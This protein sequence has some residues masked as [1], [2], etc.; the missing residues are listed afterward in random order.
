MAA[1]TEG[2]VVSAGGSFSVTHS[3]QAAAGA[4]LPPL[5]SLLLV[6]ASGGLTLPEGG[7]SPS[8]LPSEVAPTA[9]RCSAAASG[10]SPLSAGTWVLDI[11]ARGLQAPGGG[12][13]ALGS[14]P[15][16]VPRPRLCPQETFVGSPATGLMEPLWGWGCHHLGLEAS[17]CAVAVSPGGVGHHRVACLA[18]CPETAEGLR[19]SAM[20]FPWAPRCREMWVVGELSSDGCHQLWPG[21]RGVSSRSLALVAT[22][23][24]SD[25]PLCPPLVGPGQAMV[26]RGSRPPGWTRGDMT[27][28]PVRGSLWGQCSS[29]PSGLVLTPTE[30]DG[31]ARG[32]PGGRAGPLPS[33]PDPRVTLCGLAALLTH[34]S[35]PVSRV[36]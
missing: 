28:S 12:A 8:C 7:K 32:W 33:P 35:V 14:V 4:S 11:G 29:W 2:A 1:L 31:M 6:G 17:P 21:Q 25:C 34:L 20:S 3:S 10:G 16:P 26:P 18:G 23:P 24:R 22:P 27:G 15:G 30:A 36:T 9:Q 13:G 19:A 5:P